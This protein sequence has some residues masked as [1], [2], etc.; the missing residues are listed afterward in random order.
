V[1]A[2]GYDVL[3]S[4]VVHEGRLSSI[5]VDRVRMPDGSTADREIVEHPSAVAVVAVD[6]DARVVLLR[7]YRHPVG[8]LVLELPAGK[9]DD[10]GESPAETAHRELAEEVGL[11]ADELTE[12]VTFHNSSGWTDEETTVYL[13]RGLREVG[14]PQGFSAHGEEAHMEVLRLPLEQALARA[15]N[16]EIRDAKTLIGLLLAGERLAISSAQSP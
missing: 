8:D 6:A 14:A 11:A 3:D 9:L 12:L 7:Q 13:A 15:R 16:G 5:R 10:E 1:T 2:G 4:R